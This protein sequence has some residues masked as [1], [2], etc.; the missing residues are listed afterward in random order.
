MDVSQPPPLPPVPPRTPPRV[1]LPSA[2]AA[3]RSNL[4]L[5]LSL[6]LLGCFM[7]F[8]LVM[9]GGWTSVLLG[10]HASAA[11]AGGPKFEEVLVKAED[12][13]NKVALLHIDGII[14]SGGTR[15]G[16]VG[17]VKLVADQL[18]AAGKDEHVK[19]VVLAVDSPGGEV[20]ASDEI[21]RAIAE[22]QKK[23]EKPVIASLGSVAASGG[24]YVSVPCRWIVAN[25][26]TITGSIG[27]IMHLYNWRGLLDKI[28]VRPEVYKS[29]KF[30]DML[31]PD[32]SQEEVTQ[33]E[34]AMV[35]SLVNETFERFKHVVVTGRKWA[36]DQNQSNPDDKGKGLTSS[37]ADYAD[38]RVISGKQAYEL[39]FVDELGNLETAIARAKKLANVE[40]A[41]LVEYQQVF[42]LSDVF[43]LF[44]KLENKKVEVDLGMDLPQLET[45]QLYFLSPLYLR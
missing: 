7:L 23:H 12:T 34:R 19:A 18:K 20:V 24:Y 22:F 16:G 17:L 5:V 35:Q 21:S 40:K 29:G 8:A 32:R 11:R 31:S 42:N 13:A 33:E 27:V 37:W 4:W 41:S 26:L 30:K 25:E 43:R 9:L 45:G 28:G 14:A 6:A 44:G 38:G 2:P 39:G 1:L 15:R 10:G 3:R 36:A